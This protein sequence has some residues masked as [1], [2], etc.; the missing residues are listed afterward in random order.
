MDTPFSQNSTHH[1][2]ERRREQRFDL[3]LLA[4]LETLS[5]PPD[6]SPVI[7]NLFTKNISSCGAFFPSERPLEDGTRVQID[8]VLSPE[9]PII[10]KVKRAMIK[11][12]GTVLRKGPEGMAV[13]FEEGYKL[14]PLN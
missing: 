7:L 3:R 13:D 6:R 8:L 2:K 4:R 9:K 5:D 14:V 11:V 1:P 10:S 12:T